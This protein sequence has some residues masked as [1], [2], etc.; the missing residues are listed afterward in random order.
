ME[1]LVT[2]AGG[3]VTDARGQPLN[4]RAEGMELE[5]GLL[6]SN[7]TLHRALLARLAATS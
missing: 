7:Q 5:H 2:A 6:A 3:C 4:Y 1:A